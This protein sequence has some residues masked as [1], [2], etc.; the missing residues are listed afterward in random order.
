MM[1]PRSGKY[2]PATKV[3][4]LFGENPSDEPIDL[5]LDNPNQFMAWLGS[6]L[7][8]HLREPGKNEPGF[9]ASQADYSLGGSPE[10]GFQLGLSF[11]VGQARMTFF[12]PIAS[13]SRPE[14]TEAITRFGKA[15]ADLVPPLKLPKSDIN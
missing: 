10:T 3:L 15:L 6:T 14:V 8:T 2:D 13:Q 11:V 4:R 7:F 9:Q 1:K 5:E 12:L